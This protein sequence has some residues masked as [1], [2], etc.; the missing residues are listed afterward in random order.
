MYVDVAGDVGLDRYVEPV[1]VAVKLPFVEV[2]FKAPELE[3]GAEVEG[4]AV[5]PEPHGS[6]EV[7][8]KDG[9]F[10]VALDPDK[11]ELAGLVGGKRERCFLAGEP[12][13]KAS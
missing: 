9:E 5:S 7:A 12:A 4:L 3:L 13:G 10:A 6:A 8:G 1:V 2:V 11:E